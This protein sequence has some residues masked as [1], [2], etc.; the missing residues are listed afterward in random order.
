LVLVKIV[1]GLLTLGEFSV[2]FA[3]MEFTIKGG[4]P[5]NSRPENLIGMYQFTP[6]NS[7]VMSVL[8]VFTLWNS[9][10]NQSDTIGTGF[11]SSAASQTEWTQFSAPITFITS[12]YPDT[13]N[14]VIMSS[15]PDLAQAGTTLYID[16]L[17]FDE[18]VGMPFTA[19]D[20]PITLFHNIEQSLLQIDMLVM[21]TDP[22]VFTLYNS[23]GQIIRQEILEGPA[24]RVHFVPLGGLK[25]GLYV[26]EIRNDLYRQARKIII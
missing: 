8:V 4:V 21:D 6:V 15:R 14:I 17:A 18:W 24:G 23:T 20:E 26:A 2:N 10:T 16:K 22:Y 11:F 1:P 5:F 3:T 12:D 13:M 19:M 7:D 9:S 25:K